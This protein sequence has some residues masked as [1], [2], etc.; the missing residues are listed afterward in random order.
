VAE[1]LRVICETVMFQVAAPKWVYKLPFNYLKRIIVAKKTL[2][3]F[4]L[5]QVSSRRNEI[6]SQTG[7]EEQ[8]RRDVFTRIIKASLEDTSEGLSDEEVVRFVCSNSIHPDLLRDWQC[9]R[10][11]VWYVYSCLK[12]VA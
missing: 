10:H 5:E 12:E 3:E 7:S 1:C 6:L 8:A 9:L 11:A 4:M 2:N